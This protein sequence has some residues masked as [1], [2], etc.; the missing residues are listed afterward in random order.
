MAKWRVPVSPSPIPPPLFHPFS[1]RSAYTARRPVQYSSYISHVRSSS[2]TWL[3]IEVS[4]ANFTPNHARARARGRVT[5]R[6]P[7]DPLLWAMMRES[8]MIMQSTEIDTQIFHG[9]T[10]YN[11]EKLSMRR[12]TPTIAGV[13]EPRANSRV[14]FFF[15]RN[16]IGSSVRACTFC[17][18][19]SLF[20]ISE[21][22]FIFGDFR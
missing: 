15:W 3:R 10:I 9:D 8:L 1:L 22:V 19:I 21:Y 16:I 18:R 17:T 14:P 6:A 5:H 7:K 20:S 2:W 13:I 4:M 12:M 11:S